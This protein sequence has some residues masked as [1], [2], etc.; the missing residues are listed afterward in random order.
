MRTILLTGVILGLTG[1]V[2][3]W[4]AASYTDMPKEADLGA[5]LGSLDECV[6]DLIPAHGSVKLDPA[7]L[8][9]STIIP[10]TLTRNNIQTA[11]DGIP[12]HY[13]VA[14]T[15]EHDAFVRVATPNGICAQY[16]LR[17]KA[18]ALQT[19]GPVMVITQ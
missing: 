14:Q 6:V 10:D 17:D 12:L 16:L 11:A 13:V 4:P 18:G 8:A 1:C 9:W 15:A 7:P 2:G 19:G 3:N 5:I